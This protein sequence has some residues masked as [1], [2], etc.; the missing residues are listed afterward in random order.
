MRGRIT[1]RSATRW[2]VIRPVSDEMKD[3]GGKRESLKRDLAP[4][5][6]SEDRCV[7]FEVA[8][9]RHQA[10]RSL[11]VLRLACKLTSEETMA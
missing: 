1:I 11:G 7:N 8:F 4:H 2:K 9:H 5:E 10:R 3:F 6:A